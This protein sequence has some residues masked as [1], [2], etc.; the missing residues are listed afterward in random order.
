M[1]LGKEKV[2][3][4][5]KGQ[6]IYV[7]CGD[8]RHIAVEC[9][10]SQEEINQVHG[11]GQFKIVHDHSIGTTNKTG[12]T[13]TMEFLTTFKEISKIKIS[14]NSSSNPTSTKKEENDS[15]TLNKI[16]EFVTQTFHTSDTNSKSIVAIEKQNAQLGKREYGKFPSTPKVNPS[17][18]QRPGKE[19]QVNEVITLHCGKKFD[20]KVKVIKEAPSYANFLKDLRVQKCKLEAHLLKKIDLTK[21]MSSII[22]NTLPPKLKDP[23]APLISI[24]LDNINIKK[25]LHDLGAS[26]NILPGNHFDQHDLGILEQTDIILRLADKSKKIP[27]GILSDVI[28]KVDDFYYPLDFLVLETKSTYKESQPTIIL[29]RPFFCNNKCIN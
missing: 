20:N 13:S 4:F 25:A 24:T 19:H 26:V 2:V 28:I 29:R 8:S 9:M 1:N 12:T 16:M 27:L 22:S 10:R 11:Y 15:N 7:R 17:H 14:Q 3:F 6:K 23:S 5:S 21:H 18:N